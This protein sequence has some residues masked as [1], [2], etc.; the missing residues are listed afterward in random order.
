MPEYSPIPL[1]IFKA[2]CKVVWHNAGCTS[3]C[4]HA[5]CY[6]KLEWDSQN[7]NA[8]S[9]LRFPALPLLH[10]P[11]LCGM[12]RRI[13][14]KGLK[15]ILAVTGR[16]LAFTLWHAFLL[17]SCPTITFQPCCVCYTLHIWQQV[18][19]RNCFFF[20]HDPSKAGALIKYAQFSSTRS[21]ARNYA[22]SNPTSMQENLPLYQG[23]RKKKLRLKPAK[24]GPY[25]VYKALVLVMLNSRTY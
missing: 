14:N 9:V 7:S 12:T 17:L 2:H 10:V 8:T 18:N 3:C 23:T 13:L 20:K 15:Q 5:P 19:T 11:I 24:P 16:A 1:A 4:V 6:P 21:E 25:T 22:V